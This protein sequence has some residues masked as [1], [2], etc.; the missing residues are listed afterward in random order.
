MES[1]LLGRNGGLARHLGCC[2][3]GS[4][5]SL[6]IYIKWECMTSE[7]YGSSFHSVNKFSGAWHTA[8]KRISVVSWS[9]YA[10][11]TRWTAK[12]NT[13]TSKLYNTLQRGAVW[14]KTLKGEQGEGMDVWCGAVC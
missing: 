3:R 9:S 2:F 8:R 7:L 6:Y 11:R 4:G 13:P 1:W 14:S 5:G 10:G 12:I